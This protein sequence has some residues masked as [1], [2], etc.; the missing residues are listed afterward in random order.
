MVPALWRSEFLNVLATAARARV[1]TPDQAHD[2]WHVA[3]V[4]V[5]LRMMRQY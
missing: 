5:A 1:L 3:Q 4:G 2:A